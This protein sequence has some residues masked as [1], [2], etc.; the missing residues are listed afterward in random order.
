MT[1]NLYWWFRPGDG[2]ALA[3]APN[4][5]WVITVPF[6]LPGETARVKITTSEQL[7]SKSD[8]LEVITPN[9]NL[10]D[11]SRIQCRYFGKCGGCQY[12]VKYTRYRRALFQC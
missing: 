3:P 4:P 10:R 11:M 12:Q 2:L 1:H 8:L 5:P 7:H 6:T 9:G